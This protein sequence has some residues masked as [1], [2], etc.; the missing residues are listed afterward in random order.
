MKLS[1]RLYEGSVVHIHN[2]TLSFYFINFATRKNKEGEGV[3]TDFCISQYCFIWSE[4][5]LLLLLFILQMGHFS[6]VLFWQLWG[7]KS[8]IQKTNWM[9]R[10]DTFAELFVLSHWPTFNCSK[11]ITAFTSGINQLSH[12]LCHVLTAFKIYSVLST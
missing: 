8:Y 11:G 9:L 7:L 3:W 2:N 5:Y 10:T 1:Q 6:E 4:T 12:Q